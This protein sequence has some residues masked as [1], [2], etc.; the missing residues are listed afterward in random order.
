MV[1]FT[2]ILGDT[3]RP[4]DIPPPFCYSVNMTMIGRH[5]ADTTAH[6]LSAAGNKAYLIFTPPPPLKTSGGQRHELRA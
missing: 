5:Q 6:P 3:S 2:Y 1:T 4:L